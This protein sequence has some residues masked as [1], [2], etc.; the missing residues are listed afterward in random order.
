[1][2]GNLVVLGVALLAWLLLFFYLMRLER[3]IK[4]LEKR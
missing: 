2:S 1:M 3:R 4:E